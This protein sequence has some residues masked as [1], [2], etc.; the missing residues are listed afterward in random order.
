MHLETA[1]L[2][3]YTPPEI[4]N[5]L[6]DICADQILDQLKELC[7]NSPFLAILADETTDKVTQIQLSVCFRFTETIDNGVNVRELF[8]GFMHAKATTGEA[9]AHLLLEFIIKNG[10][11]LQKLRAQ[12]YDGASNMSDRHNGVQALIRN[13]APDAVY[14]HC[15][16]HC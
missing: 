13:H 6:I 9:I 11:C 4:Q 1:T 10:I 5:E 2:V 7:S 12:G 14:V 3:K 8:L 15:K 16:G